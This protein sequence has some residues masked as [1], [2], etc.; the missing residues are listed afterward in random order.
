MHPRLAGFG[1]GSMA[2][3]DLNQPLIRKAG[4]PLP[5]WR[6]VFSP[7]LIS[8]GLLLGIVTV[9]W[10]AVVDDPDGGRT[11]VMAPIEDAAPAATGSVEG[12]DEASLTAEVPLEAPQAAEEEIEVAALPVAPARL[13]TDP[14]LVES[15]ALGPLPRISPDG[16]LPR[17]V[18]ARRS[19][20]VP[21]GTPR[22][23]IV[24]GGLGISQTGTQEAIERL[25][26]DVTLA[27]AP[28]G[29]SLQRW[30]SKARD[31]GH[32]VILQVPLEPVGYPQ[33]NPGEHTLLVAAG[34]A[35]HDHLGWVLSRMTSPM[36]A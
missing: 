9:F 32:E 26:E 29:S 34:R 3:N 35:N 30:V 18:Y 31:E 23:A 15:S 36:P 12:S 13:D 4:R 25:P 8:A 19:A 21:Q 14:S 11:V 17:E 16:R 7:L 5:R 20:P 1:W 33:E 22:I 2:K 10:V 24:I 28:Y 27:F 6:P